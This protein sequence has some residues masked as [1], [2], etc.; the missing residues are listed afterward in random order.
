MPA[1]G[2]HSSAEVPRATSAHSG[3]VLRRFAPRK[4]LGPTF[5]PDPVDEVIELGGKGRKIGAW[6]VLLGLALSVP[7]YFCG[8]FTRP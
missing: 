5:A 1:P 3:D 6:V 4:G 7:T 2:S 8:P